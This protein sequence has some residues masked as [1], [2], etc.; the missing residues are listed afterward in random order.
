ML[1]EEPERASLF[2]KCHKAPKSHLEAAGLVLRST[3]KDK[4][5]T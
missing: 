2:F 3:Y 4:K 1:A 5:V